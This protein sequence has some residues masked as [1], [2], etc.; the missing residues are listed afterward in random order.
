MSDP[1]VV[2]IGT[3]PAGVSAAYPLVEAGLQVLMIDGGRQVQEL[4]RD[5]SYL[6]LRR[7]ATSQWKVFLGEQL[8]AFAASGS[9]SPKLRS[10][11]LAPVF[12][13]YRKAYQAELHDFTLIGSLAAGG[14]SNA[15]GAGVSSF[16][17]ADLTGFPIKTADLALSYQAVAARIGLSGTKDDDLCDL[18]R[19]GR[20]VAASAC[21]GQQCRFPDR[22]LSEASALCTGARMSVWTCAQRRLDRATRGS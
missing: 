2:I 19:F 22:P 6:D 15:W 5:A 10:G 7:N 17:D 4:A 20:A 18:F 9:N 16:N 12:E 8:E 21:F 1:D 3:G 13:G 14:L 11:T